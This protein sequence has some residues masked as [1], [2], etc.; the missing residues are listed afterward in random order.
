MKFLITIATLSLLTACG[1]SRVMTDPATT[2]G[3]D[4]LAKLYVSW[5]KDK[6]DKWDMEVQL[7]NTSDKH[8][9]IL[10]NDISCARGET[11]GM[12]RHT[13]FNTGERTIQFSPGQFKSFIA[14]CTLPGD[15]TGDFSVTVAKVWDNPSSDGKTPGKEI[16]GAITWK[17]A[18][19]AQ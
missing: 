3:K 19:T 8:I 12:L 4:G 17:H 2:A 11:Q 15:V 6:G 14:V 18:A 16:G 1:H 7:K 13:F 9:I 10:L 5:V